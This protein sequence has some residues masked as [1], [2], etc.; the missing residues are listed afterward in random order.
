MKQDKGKAQTRG[1]QHRSVRSTAEWVTLSASVLIVLTLAAL[2]LYQQFTQGTAPPVIEVQPR[3]QELRQEGGAF[4]LP[5]E[6]T[7]KGE[8][9][10]EDIEVQLTLQ[11]KDKEPETIQ[12]QV[13]LLAGGESD[14]Q[15]AIFQNDPSKGDITHAVAF[16]A[17]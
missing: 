14:T 5:V 16:S 1:D 7:N 10:A 11:T 17:H 6:I 12:F 8:V 13:K 2:V 9:T 15:T 4:Y 3:L